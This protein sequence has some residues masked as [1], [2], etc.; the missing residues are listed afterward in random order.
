[1][2][3]EENWGVLTTPRGDGFERQSIPNAAVDY[4]DF[5]VNL[6]DA[7]LG[8]AKLAVSP[9]WALRVMRVLELARESSER[10]CTVPYTRVELV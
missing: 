10:G 5:Y 1:M 3:N 2:Q 6:R 9:E 4:R 7:L 8:K